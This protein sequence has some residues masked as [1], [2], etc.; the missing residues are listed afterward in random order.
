MVTTYR[1]TGER[2]RQDDER[3]AAAGVYI[4]TFQLK[5]SYLM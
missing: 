4:Y 5:Q 1:L 2:C 3:R